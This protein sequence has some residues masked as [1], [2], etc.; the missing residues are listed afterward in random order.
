MWR[1]ENQ[2]FKRSAKSPCWFTSHWGDRGL[3][4]HKRTSLGTQPSGTLGKPLLSIGL[5]IPWLSP[6][7]ETIRF[8]LILQN[9]HQSQK[10][11]VDTP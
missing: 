4:A 3:K 1:S 9:S 5:G 6:E 8:T 10:E 2:R 11:K 7:P